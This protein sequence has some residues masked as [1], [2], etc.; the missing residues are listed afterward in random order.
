MGKDIAMTDQTDAIRRELQRALQQLRSVRL[1][2]TTVETTLD[3][4]LLQL[5]EMGKPDPVTRGSTFD[6][7]V[8]KEPI[9]RFDPA[10]WRKDVLIKPSVA[11]SPEQV[12]YK[13]SVEVVQRDE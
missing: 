1:T 12:T 2:L 4:C 5:N 9:K 11:V 8:S 6:E 7:I 10:E 13:P 3:L